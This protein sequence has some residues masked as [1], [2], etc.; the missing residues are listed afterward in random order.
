[1]QTT[2]LSS[3]GQVIL[4]KSLRDAFDWQP[5]TPFSVEPVGDGVLL[6]PMKALAR[7]RLQDVAGCIRVTG[8]ARTIA[9]MDAAIGEEVRRRRDRGRY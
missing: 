9:Q 7:S 4:P 1:M 8:P 5:G 6:R 2:R 3:K